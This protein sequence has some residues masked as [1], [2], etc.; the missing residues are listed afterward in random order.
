MVK[1]KVRIAQCKNIERAIL[2]A[3]LKEVTLEVQK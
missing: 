3:M 2:D 1:K